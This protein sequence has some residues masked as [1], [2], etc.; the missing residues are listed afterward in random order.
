MKFLFL[1]NLNTIQRKKLIFSK[2]HLN[3]III[4]KNKKILILPNKNKLKN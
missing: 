2:K 1:I 4:E 3:K